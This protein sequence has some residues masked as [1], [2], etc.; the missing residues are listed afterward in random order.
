MNVIK[1]VKA[2][3]SDPEDFIVSVSKKW[4]STD[5]IRKELASES[6]A[7]DE[8]HREAVLL[9]QSSHKQKGSLIDTLCTQK[10][11]GLPMDKLRA[12]GMPANLP[13]AMEGV[14]MEEY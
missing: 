1:S 14:L 5:L 11:Q 2:W 10:K 3:V 6:I 7:K 8:Y 12:E 9:I 13:A 4:L